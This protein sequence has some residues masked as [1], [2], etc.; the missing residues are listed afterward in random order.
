MTKEKDDKPTEEAMKGYN[1]ADRDFQ[2]TEKDADAVS[3]SEK[4]VLERQKTEK[5]KEDKPAGEAL[6]GYN[7]ADRDFQRTEKDVDN[8]SGSERETAEK[9]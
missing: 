6:K 5:G 9:K 1:A 7:P 2:R 3:G 4:E 8:V